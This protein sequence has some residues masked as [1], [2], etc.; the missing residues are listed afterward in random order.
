MRVAQDISR[1]KLAA[2]A[3]VTGLLLSAHAVKRI[4]RGER[5]VLD[6]ELQKLARALRVP[7]G[8]FLEQAGISKV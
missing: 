8:V 5:A 4:E 6:F 1:E 7:I 2:R 3:Q